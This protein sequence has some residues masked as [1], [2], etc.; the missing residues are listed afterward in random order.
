MDRR[1]GSGFPAGRG[2]LILQEGKIQKP[3]ERGEAG[4]RHLREGGKGVGEKRGHRGTKE[5]GASENWW[6]GGEQIS[7]KGVHPS[8]L[9]F[10][11]RVSWAFWRSPDASCWTVLLTH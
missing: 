8:L 9:P 7:E 6:S 5:C 3:K 4:N 1:V 11:K 10:Q 2:A